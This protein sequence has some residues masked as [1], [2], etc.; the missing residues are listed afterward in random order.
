MVLDEGRGSPLLIIAGFIQKLPTTLVEAFKS[1][2]A[3]T[4]AGIWCFWWWTTTRTATGDC[5]REGHLSLRSAQKQIWQAAVNKC[6]LHED[7]MAE[8]FR[9]P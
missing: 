8:A 1:T 2:L 7:Q 9:P 4:S 6:D 5:R 3:E